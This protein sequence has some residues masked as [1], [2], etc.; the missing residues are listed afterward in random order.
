MQLRVY[1]DEWNY[2]NFSIATEPVF[3]WRCAFRVWRVAF[4]VGQR[5][6]KPFIKLYKVA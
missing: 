4:A 3:M 5:Q 1:G 6:W 2:P